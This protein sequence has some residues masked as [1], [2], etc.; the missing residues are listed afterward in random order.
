[1]PGRPTGGAG[2]YVASRESCGVYYCRLCCPRARRGVAPAANMGDELYVHAGG[3]NADEAAKVIQAHP[4]AIHYMDK[5][6]GEVPLHMVRP[7]C[8]P[9]SVN[10]LR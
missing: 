7:A 1:L 9:G 4:D 6:S 5:E 2:P 8:T 3:G 10:C